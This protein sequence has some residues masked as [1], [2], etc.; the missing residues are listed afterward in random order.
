MRKGAVFRLFVFD[1]VFYTKVANYN[2]WSCDIELV[3]RKSETIVLNS[4][5]FEFLFHKKRNGL[6]CKHYT[7]RKFWTCGENLTSHLFIASVYIYFTPSMEILSC[8]RKIFRAHLKSYARTWQARRAKWVA[9]AKNVCAVY[10]ICYL[11]AQHHKLS[12]DI[13]GTENS[14]ALVSQIFHSGCT[15]ADHTQW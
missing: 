2:H 8:A 7:P 1:A 11:R 9:R 6:P 3:H 10:P 15:A 14:A 13:S 12:A 5:S 4:N